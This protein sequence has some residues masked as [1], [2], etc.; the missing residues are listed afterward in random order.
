MGRSRRHALGTFDAGLATLLTVL[1]GRERLIDEWYMTP[2]APPKVTQADTQALDEMPNDGWFD[3]HA[4][5]SYIR[6]P[7]YRCQRLEKAG[8]LE[9]R[10]EGRYPLLST[11]YRRRP[12]ARQHRGE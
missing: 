8:L 12:D 2:N 10:V 9:S 4:L 11:R 6:R 3:P 5:P 7:L 1:K